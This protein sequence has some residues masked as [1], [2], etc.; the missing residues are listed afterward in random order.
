LRLDA[1]EGNN[2]GTAQSGRALAETRHLGAS[3]DVGIGLPGRIDIPEQTGLRRPQVELGRSWLDA[4]AKNAD[5]PVARSVEELCAR[6]RRNVGQ[7]IE[8]VLDIER[9]VLRT[10]DRGRQQ[11]ALLSADIGEL[12]V[13]DAAVE[14][15]DASD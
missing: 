8:A 2:R 7:E 1:G 3:R 14:D 5:L 4:I 10:I 12:L 15:I 13:V 9:G 11:R 6:D